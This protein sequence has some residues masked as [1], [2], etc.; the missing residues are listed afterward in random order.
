[1]A[2]LVEHGRANK[3]NK[4]RRNQRSRSALLSSS[5]RHYN[6]NDSYLFFVLLLFVFFLIYSLHSLH[7]YSKFP[8]FFFSHV[9]FFLSLFCL[10]LDSPRP[11]GLGWTMRRWLTRTLSGYFVRALYVLVREKSVFRSCR[12]WP[13]QLSH[14]TC[15]T[16]IRHI[17]R[18]YNKT[19]V[20]AKPPPP[21]M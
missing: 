2:R 21:P 14:G 15:K 12:L 7:Y 10:L 6:T 8:L 16:T 19:F 18:P 20:P 11:P 1:M 3:L 4:R 17:T 5:S 13:D 9:F